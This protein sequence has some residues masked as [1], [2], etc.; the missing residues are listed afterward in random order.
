VRIPQAQ[1]LQQD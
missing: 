1:E